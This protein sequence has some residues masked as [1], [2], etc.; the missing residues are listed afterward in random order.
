MTQDWRHW[1]DCCTGGNFRIAYKQG[2]VWL[3]EIWVSSH[4]EFCLELVIR[5]FM[6]DSQVQVFDSL[7][8]EWYKRV[9]VFLM[10]KV[11]ADYD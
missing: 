8:A 1:L 6:D 4:V 9:F 2:F 11:F 5:D 7:K 3:A 10:K